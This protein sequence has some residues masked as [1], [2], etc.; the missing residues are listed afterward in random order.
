[1][2]GK[3][4]P[5]LHLTDYIPG[6]TW[7][8]T[9]L[10][11]PEWTQYLPLEEV[12]IPEALKPAGYI[13]GHFGKWHLNQD[14]NYQPG[15]PM[16][17][18]SQGF[19]DVLTTVKPK[20]DADPTTDPHH[21]TQI[22]GRALNFI[23]KYQNQPF[24]CYV[25]HNTI[26]NPVM[27]RPEL[28]AKYQAKSGAENQ[29]NNPVVAA[30]VETL[31]TEVGRILQK[32]D[33][34]NLTDKTMVIFFSDNGAIRAQADLK[35]L[36][37]G[38]AQLYE[39]GIRVPLIVCWPG[40]IVPGTSCQEVVSS[41]DFFPTLVEAAGLTLD[42][43]QI[44]GVSILPLLK[45]S[46]SLARKAIFWHYPHYHTA[47]IAPSGAIRKGKY[48]L[49]EWFEQ[50]I[51]GIDTEGALELFDL[52]TDPSEQHNLIKMMP[53]LGHQLY[54]QLQDWR[55]QV[56]AQEMLRNPNYDPNKVRR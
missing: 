11:T 7:P 48:K 30:M 16:D 18:A 13:A 3:Y 24:F 45:Q 37:G 50:S 55:T 2:T 34:L 31:D 15:R 41:I 38:K 47:G 12:T 44:D 35:P 54:Q 39:G 5:R 21:V 1:M 19:D 6:N 22:T 8:F 14:K 53:D 17:P 26:H 56:G 32:L 40:A 29:K 46:G 27:E 49:I 20:P 23:E 52:E 43:H 25:T 4:P 33:E 10:M 42:S 51:D 9:K 28:I 36:R